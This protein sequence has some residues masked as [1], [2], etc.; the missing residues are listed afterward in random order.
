MTA[1]DPAREPANRGGG[2]GNREQQPALDLRGQVLAGFPLGVALATLWCA[3]N[4]F[5]I[6]PAFAAW[7]RNP[8]P[9][10]SPPW[11]HALAPFLCGITGSLAAAWQARSRGRRCGPVLVAGFLLSAILGIAA[12]YRFQALQGMT[13]RDLDP[14]AITFMSIAERA[15]IYNTAMREPLFVWMIKGMRLLGGEYS[16]LSLRLFGVVL[17]LG[18]VAGVFVF[19][20]A[21]IGLVAAVIASLFYAVAPAFVFSATRGLREDTIIILFLWYAH[22]LLRMWGRPPEWRSYAAL[23]VVLF[24]NIALRM[25][26]NGFGVLTVLGLFGWSAW[27]HRV[28]PRKWW[29]AV[30]PPAISFVLLSPYLLY[31]KHKY[32]DAFY[33]VSIHTRFYANLE[34]AGKPGFP[35]KK[36]AELDMYSGPPISMGEYLFRHHTPEEVLQGFLFGTWRLY[37]SGDWED[38]PTAAAPTWKRTP[39][40]WEYHFSDFNLERQPLV[41]KSASNPVLFPWLQLLGIAA[42]VLPGRRLFL[43]LV[44]LFHGPGLFLASLIEFDWRLLTVA[45]ASFYIGIGA[46]GET[47][48]RGS[49][50]LARRALTRR[51]RGVD[52]GTAGRETAPNSNE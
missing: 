25:S 16:P 3:W 44:F 32:G 12:W 8:V 50:N 51:L 20:R 43:A 14:D 46:A 21:H 19:T 23:G 33:C 30:L 29:I 52:A 10:N 48:F 15:N 45:M 18:A 1:D 37:F 17:S 40:E 24:L 6:Y 4:A 39:R 27:K 35:T 36:Q 26:T 34:F 22:L 31:S 2:P 7:M 5:G 13:L 28:P 47:V 42:M 38:F 41:R 49:G 9:A 11:F